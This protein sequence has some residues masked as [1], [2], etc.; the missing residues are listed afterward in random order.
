M[1]FGLLKRL[2]LTLKANSFGCRFLN[3]VLLRS[4]HGFTCTCAAICKSLTCV[5]QLY[6]GVSA[7]FL[8][9]PAGRFLTGSF[10][11]I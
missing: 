9:R 5:K 8:T 6:T 1:F 4:A 3:L 10:A 11:D 7:T 2:R